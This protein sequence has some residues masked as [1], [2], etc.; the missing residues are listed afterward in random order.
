VEKSIQRCLELRLCLS[1]VEAM[2]WARVG[3]ELV[4]E[5]QIAVWWAYIRVER[6]ALGRWGVGGGVIVLWWLRRWV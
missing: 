6:S 4:G 2:W 1:E 5:T 3:M